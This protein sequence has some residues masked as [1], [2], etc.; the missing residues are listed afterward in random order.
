MSRVE[1]PFVEPSVGVYFE[2]I[3]SVV[4]SPQVRPFDGGGA[5]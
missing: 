1:S 3:I 2:S 4:F 5:R